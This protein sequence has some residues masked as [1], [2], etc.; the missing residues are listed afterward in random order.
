MGWIELL[1]GANVPDETRQQ[2]YEVIERNARAQAQLVNDVLDVSRIT[3]GKLRLD[4]RPVAL[5]PVVEKA[6]DSLRASALGKSLTLT[7]ELEEVG[8]AKVDATRIAQ[9]V[10]NLLQNAI[11][12]TPEGGEITVSLHREDDIALLRVSDNGVG[13][14]ESF[15]PHVF[16]RFR[17]ADSSATRP[18]GGLGLGLA[19]VR[20][21]VEM[22]GGEV[23]VASGGEN[24]GATFTVKLPVEAEPTSSLEQ[25]SNGSGRTLQSLP[26]GLHLLVVD[27]DLDTRAMIVHL[28]SMQ[29]AD[30]RQAESGQR[31]LNIV[32][33]EEWRPDV[34]VSD[35]GMPGMD[36]YELRRR[37]REI[38]PGVPAVALTAY[39]A[40]ADQRRALDAGFERYLSKPVDPSNVISAVMDLAP[41][42]ISEKK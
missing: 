8:D 39:A 36:G 7:T 31:A 26:P 14:A 35:V 2:A 3:T 11:K 34:I 20:H 21:I 10:W 28:L 1:R 32:Q 42:H 19:I 18:A 17:Q 6:I 40:P 12:F 16:D 37:F 25:D 4:F 13:I 29:G 24:K 38:L 9:V 5:T 41:R 30:V 33:Q 27:D 22:H 23:E 15:L